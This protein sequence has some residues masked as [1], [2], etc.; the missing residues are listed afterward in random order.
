LEQK[1]K[2]KIF[3]KS[4][5]LESYG[6]NDLAWGREDALQLINEIMEHKIGIL[7]GDVYRL[8]GSRLDPLSDNWSCE[9]MEKERELSSNAR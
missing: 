3:R 1:I 2:E 8:V 6:L 4:I 7:G 5:S 9:P